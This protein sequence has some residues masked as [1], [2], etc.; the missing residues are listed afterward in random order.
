MMILEINMKKELKR[1]L[2][3]VQKEITD[4][5]QLNKKKKQHN[6]NA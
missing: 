5:S 3:Y 2:T 4:L 1:S 6:K